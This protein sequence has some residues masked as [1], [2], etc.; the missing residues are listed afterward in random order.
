MYK[1]LLFDVDGTLW[2][3]TEVVAKAWI[4]A[5]KELGLPY[6]VITADRLKREFG[7]PMDEIFEHLFPDNK[8]PNLYEKMRDLLYVYEHDFLMANETD[9]AYPKVR[10][11]IQEL[12]KNHKIFIVSNCQIGYI[13]LVMEKCGIGD[14]ISDYLCYGDTLSPKNVTMEKLME[15][16]GLS[17]AD[18]CYIGDIQGDCDST[19]LA[20]LDFVHASWG[21]GEVTGAELTVATFADLLKEV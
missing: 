7:I 4:K 15:K 6:E 2:N 10:E 9:L 5:A 19:H 11:T 14:Y 3:S 12:S 1:N 17:K 18:T 16:N 21:F 8:L 13:E 20:G